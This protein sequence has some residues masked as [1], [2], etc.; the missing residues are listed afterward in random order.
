MFKKV[1]EDR[2]LVLENFFWILEDSGM[3]IFVL[4]FWNI[5][6]VY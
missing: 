6:G 1:Y 5:C 2:G 4:I 3:V